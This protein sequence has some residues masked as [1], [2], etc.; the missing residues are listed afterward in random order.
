MTVTIATPFEEMKNMNIQWLSA[1]FSW[2]NIL[3][4]EE[5]GASS[6]QYDNSVS[7]NTSTRST[8]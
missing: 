5:L 8:N 1:T 2:R 4:K 3:K 7:I 6:A